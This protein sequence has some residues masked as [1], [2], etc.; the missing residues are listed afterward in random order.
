AP[1]ALSFD[2]ELEALLAEEEPLVVSMAAKSK[3]GVIAFLVEQDLWQQD[4]FWQE[5]TKE[6]E[7]DA[8][9]RIAN[10]LEALVQE[11][12]G[13]GDATG[14]GKGSWQGQGKEEGTKEQMPETTAGAAMGAAMPAAMK[15]SIGGTKGLALPATKMS[16]TKPVSKRR[17]RQAPRYEVSG[18][19]LFLNLLFG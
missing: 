6:S 5:V 11:G 4:K 3:E 16:S 7:A 9:Q 18:K 1:A 17:G 19:T 15:A 13:L 14:T 12:L 2:E 10:S 8:Q